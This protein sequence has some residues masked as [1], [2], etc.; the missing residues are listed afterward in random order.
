MTDNNVLTTIQLVTSVLCVICHLL[1]LQEPEVISVLLE[2]RDP[3]G[4]GFDICGSMR[5]GI[6]VSQ[7]HNRGPAI[8]T[9]L[10]KIGKVYLTYL[11]ILFVLRSGT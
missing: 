3:I 7:V 4:L 11:L 10:V 9:G 6:Y 2:S 8:E 1:V 5:D